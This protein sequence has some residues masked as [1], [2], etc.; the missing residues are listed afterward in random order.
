MM[1]VTLCHY[2]HIYSTLVVLPNAWLSPA[3]IGTS[4]ELKEL[5]SGMSAKLK[6]ILNK[7]LEVIASG[8]DQEVM[9]IVNYES[10]K[11][12][13]PYAVVVEGHQLLV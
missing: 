1:V 9:A 7:Q 10:V 11:A 13:Q 2:P 3:L 5:F 4:N 12:E 8:S 6:L